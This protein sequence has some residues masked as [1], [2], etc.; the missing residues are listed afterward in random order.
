M[1]K[2]GYPDLPEHIKEHEKLIAEITHYQELFNEGKT[3]LSED[4]L[5]FLQDWLTQHIKVTDKRYS[6]LFNG[7]NIS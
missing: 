6:V 2:V 7:N 4:I 1:K 5:V 3:D